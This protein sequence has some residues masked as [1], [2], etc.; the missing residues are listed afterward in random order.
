MSPDETSDGGPQI[1]FR[2]RMNRDR[3]PA[4]VTGTSGVA[5]SGAEQR[6]NRNGR[7]LIPAVVAD[8][9]ADLCFSPRRMETLVIPEG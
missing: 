9:H 2:D 4:V 1:A 6:N 8:L 3:E 7:L 5:T